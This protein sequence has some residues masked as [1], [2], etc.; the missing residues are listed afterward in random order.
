MAN[1]SGP[2]SSVDRADC[3]IVGGGV[4]G[5]AVA[6]RFASAGLE[7]LVLE[8]EAVHGSHTSSRNSEVIHAGLYY[9][10]GSLKARLC[11]SGR[12]QLYRYC[13][14]RGVPYR[15]CGKLIVATSEEERGTLQGYLEAARRNGVT[16]VAWRTA[17]E[18]AAIEPAVRCTAALCSPSTGILDSHA[19]MQALL[20]DLEASGGC[21][22]CRAEVVGGS[23]GRG[24]HRLLVQQG[25]TGIELEAR[26]LVNAAGLDAPSV[27]RRFEGLDAAT[28]PP[29]HLAKGH[30]FT[31]QGRAP[32]RHLVYPV[33]SSAGLGIHVT[34]D[35]GG[36]ARF[37]PD[38]EWVTAVDYSCDESRREAF[39][40]AI[41]RYYPALDAGRL[42]PAYTGIRPKISGPGEPAADF[43]IQ[44]TEGHGWEGLV[45]L[46]GIESPGL[47][48]AL[49]IA[50]EVAARLGVPRGHG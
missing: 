2:W 32:F 38:V 34:L 18:V 39:A 13:D 19:F 46:Y 26:L 47:T 48:A 49:A 6:R 27:A 42:Q 45:N 25:A 9:P 31:L 50:D 22:A 16:D 43:C 5:L 14:D 40:E 8:R 36:Q 33:A 35:L 37:G 10:P 11:V 4:V 17:A 29:R 3:I 23:L 41:R 20:G 15:R 7:T 28:I 12:E 24:S 1:Q 30:Y 21:L 44:G